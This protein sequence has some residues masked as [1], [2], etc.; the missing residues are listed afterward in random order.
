MNNE[1]KLSEKDI[2]LLKDEFQEILLKEVRKNRWASA[3]E[4]LMLKKVIE[5]VKKQME[6]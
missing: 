3:E 5:K 6:R 2:N 1:Y 4:Y